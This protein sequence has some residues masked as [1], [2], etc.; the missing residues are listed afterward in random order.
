MGDHHMRSVL[1][2]TVIVVLGWA[3]LTIGVFG[4]FGPWWAMIVSGTLAILGAITLINVDEPIR[5]EDRK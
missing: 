5:R 4:Q 1:I 2:S 3:A